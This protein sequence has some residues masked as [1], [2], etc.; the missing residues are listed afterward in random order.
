MHLAGEIKC[1]QQQASETCIMLAEITAAMTIM[2][3]RNTLL[4][5]L[6]L[7]AFNVK[8]HY[9]LFSIAACLLKF[10]LKMRLES[11][12]RLCAACILGDK[13]KSALGWLILTIALR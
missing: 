4:P 2:M 7:F 3:H 5:H 9:L 8:G 11:I 6:L 1:S 13:K 12:A 10:F